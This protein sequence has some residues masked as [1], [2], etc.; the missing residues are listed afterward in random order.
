M[1]LFS[2]TEIQKYYICHNI[3]SPTSWQLD[4]NWQKTWEVA[5]CKHGDRE[6]SIH[7]LLVHAILGLFIAQMRMRLDSDPWW[8]LSKLRKKRNNLLSLGQH[9]PQ[10]MRW[11]AW[12]PHLINSQQLCNMLIARDIVQQW[13]INACNAIVFN[14]LVGHYWEIDFPHFC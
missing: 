11:S 2:A 13:I 14:I 6:V 9:T 4:I 1:I 12:L 3:K 7:N 5:L 8:E 10:T